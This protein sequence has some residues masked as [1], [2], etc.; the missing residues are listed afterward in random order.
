MSKG[1]GGEQWPLAEDCK[2][3]VIVCHTFL[4]TEGALYMTHQQFLSLCIILP[5][6]SIIPPWRP[7]SEIITIID[8][9]W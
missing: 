1:G 7:T 2:D 8:S 9:N 3:G 4:R 5:D 6:H